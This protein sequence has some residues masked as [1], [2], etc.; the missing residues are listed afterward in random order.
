MIKIKSG[1]SMADL[2]LIMGLISSTAPTRL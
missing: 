2:I 1:V